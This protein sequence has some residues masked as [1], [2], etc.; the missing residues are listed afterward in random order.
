MSNKK[1]IEIYFLTEEREKRLWENCIFV[2]D[3]S[4]I[5]NLY[6]YSKLILDDISKSIFSKLESQERLWIPQRVEYEFFKNREDKITEPIQQYK[7]LINNDHNNDKKDKNNDKY[8]VQKIDQSIKHIEQIFNEEI[9]EITVQLN[10]LSQ[11]IKKQDRHPYFEDPLLIRDFQNI[12]TNFNDPVKNELEQLHDIE[13]LKKAFDTFQNKIAEEIKN[14][15]KEINKNFQIF[16]GD[17]DKDPV[18]K[19]F[20]CFQVGEEYSFGELREIAK[21]G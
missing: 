5:L 8:Y 6:Y 16:T 12:I 3:T 10:A 19:I 14:K 18:F 11:K 15:E 7:D 9:R 21:E 17:K 1:S 4:A 13:K 2:F 20:N